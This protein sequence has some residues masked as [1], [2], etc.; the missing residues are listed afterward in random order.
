VN[1]RA[2]GGVFLLPVATWEA[3]MSEMPSRQAALTGADVREL[4]GDVL[5]WKVAAILALGPSPSD[6][7]AAAAWA[8]GEDELGQRGRP[9][10]GL[11]A[12]VYDVLKADDYPEEH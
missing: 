12:Q 5:D 3:I 11:A 9:L 2:P 8:Q 7:G 10:Q 4:C 6:V 1:A